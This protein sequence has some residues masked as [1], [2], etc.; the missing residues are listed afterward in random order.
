MT[1]L[2]VLEQVFTLLKDSPTIRW[3]EFDIEPVLDAV[4]GVVFSEI[5][6][7]PSIHACCALGIM[8][9]VIICHLRSRNV[10]GHGQEEQL[11]ILM[12]YD[13]LCLG[14]E[15][16]RLRREERRPGDPATSR[17]ASSPQYLR[18]LLVNGPL[19]N[20][21]I[22]AL[23]MVPHLENKEAIPE[24][25]WETLE[26]LKSVIESLDTVPDDPVALNYFGVVRNSGLKAVIE[27]EGS[28][29]EEQFRLIDYMNAVGGRLGL[30]KLSMPN[31]VTPPQTP[32][33]QFVPPN[34]REYAPIYI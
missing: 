2:Q 31:L 30:P 24:I 11:F 9:N 25:A 18:N 20:F 19:Q 26:M 5:A 3:C 6:G 15:P 21:S 17:E 16:E 22:M 33:G 23:H 10:Q 34:R 1:C 14:D 27:A 28:P 32:G 13:W 29:N 4:N 7:D 8:I 12:I